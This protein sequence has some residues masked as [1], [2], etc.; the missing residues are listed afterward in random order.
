MQVI[1]YDLQQG[2]NKDGT[3]ILAPATMS[4]SEANLYV[5]KKEAY[6]GEYTVEDDG[7]Q[8]TP[9]ELTLEERV[10]ALEKSAVYPAYVP[11]TYYYRGDK[12]SLEGVNYVCIA[13]AGVVCVWSPTEYP[14]YWEREV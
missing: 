8:P 4:Y 12:V 10:T 9:G 5:A 14:A 7:I 13:P 1:K 2:A 11:G 6:N 3:P